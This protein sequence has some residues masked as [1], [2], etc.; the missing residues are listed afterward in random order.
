MWRV[1]SEVVRKTRAEEEAEEAGR[2]R[3]RGWAR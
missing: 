3:E 1:Q 2:G